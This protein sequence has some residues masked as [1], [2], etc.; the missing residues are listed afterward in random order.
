MNT[1]KTGRSRPRVTHTGGELAY[2]LAF[3]GG[4]G[5]PWGGGSRVCPDHLWEAPC[6]RRDLEGRYPDGRVGSRRFD[7]RPAE[8]DPARDRHADDA[9]D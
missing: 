3:D 8:R 6:R 5:S 7:R 1:V 9:A 4:I 2:G